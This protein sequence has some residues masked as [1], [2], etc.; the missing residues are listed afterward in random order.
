MPDCCGDQGKGRQWLTSLPSS[1]LMWNQLKPSSNVSVL[2]IHLIYLPW[3]NLEEWL[4]LFYLS[5]KLPALKY[6]DLKEQ[7]NSR[8][9]RAELA[10]S[11]DIS[12]ENKL[13]CV[14]LLST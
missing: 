8:E 11:R 5:K 2:N 7:T 4:N 6:N 13:S 1:Q 12:C 3:I 14:T 10:V 9:Q